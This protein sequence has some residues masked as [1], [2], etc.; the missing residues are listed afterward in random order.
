MRHSSEYKR[1]IK[2]RISPKGKER[3]AKA[4]KL[5][6]ERKLTYMAIG[7]QMGLTPERIR[8]MCV[9]SKRSRDA[10][11]YPYGGTRKTFKVVESSYYKRAYQLE[12]G[13]HDG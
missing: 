12:N 7:D 8:Q 5:R 1:W 11:E 6:E 9:K 10:G 3:E 2:V 4:L 13:N